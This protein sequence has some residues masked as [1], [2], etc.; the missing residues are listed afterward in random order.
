MSFEFVPFCL[1]NQ[2]LQQIFNWMKIMKGG[3]IKKRDNRR[4]FVFSKETS[5]RGPVST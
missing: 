5:G 1:T 3:I 4:D 2:F